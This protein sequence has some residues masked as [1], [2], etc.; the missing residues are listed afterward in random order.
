VDTFPPSCVHSDSLRFV[1]ETLVGRTGAGVFGLSI[2]D[3]G[4]ANAKIMPHPAIDAA[5]DVAL[6][7]LR[8]FLIVAPSLPD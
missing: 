5:N 1:G 2:A 8:I 7:F 4:A 6:I 3:A